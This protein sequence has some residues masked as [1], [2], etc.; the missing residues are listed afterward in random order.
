M[1]HRRDFFKKFLPYFVKESSILWRKSLK[2]NTKSVIFLG[3]FG[4]DAKLFGDKVRSE[5][6]KNNIIFERFSSLGMR[7]S[8]SL[9]AYN[10]LIYILQFRLSA[11]IN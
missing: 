5:I 2:P 8:V 11:E 4:A 1:R 9:V 7:Q 3:A 6:F 10:E